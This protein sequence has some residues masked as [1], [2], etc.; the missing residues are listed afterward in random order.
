MD[1]ATHQIEFSI[2][3]LNTGINS[4]WWFYEL[5][6]WELATTA[7]N[8]RDLFRLMIVPPKSGT[9][10]SWKRYMKAQ[11]S[12]DQWGKANYHAIQESCCFHAIQI[13]FICSFN[14]F[15][16]SVFFLSLMIMT[17]LLRIMMKRTKLLNKW[18]DTIHVSYIFE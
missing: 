15:Q 2:F 10:L 3:F 7:L 6:N 13:W 18:Y 4:V 12:M 14:K 16:R 1:E 9:R 17:D 8:W 11:K 5:H